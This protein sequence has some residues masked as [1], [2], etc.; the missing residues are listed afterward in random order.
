MA[1]LHMDSKKCVEN[2]FYMQAVFHRPE[3]SQKN[4]ILYTDI[5]LQARKRAEKVGP[6]EKCLSTEPKEKTKSGPE[7]ERGSAESYSYS[8]LRFLF[9]DHII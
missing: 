6:R 9:C 3:K 7:N 5:V 8:S 1:C 2:W 4:W